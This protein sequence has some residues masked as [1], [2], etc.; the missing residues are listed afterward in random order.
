[1]SGELEEALKAIEDVS[2]NFFALSLE[3]GSK[4]RES[5][6]I[7]DVLQDALCTIEEELSELLAQA[8][9]LRD[10]EDD[11]HRKDAALKRLTEGLD[12]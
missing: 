9:K 7:C 11:M 5:E 8:S 2:N 1:M 6:A 3:G 10:L 4:G 12:S